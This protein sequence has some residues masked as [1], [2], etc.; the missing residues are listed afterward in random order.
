MERNY[1]ERSD[2]VETKLRLLETAWKGRRFELARALAHSIHEAAVFA[3]QFGSE[4]GPSVIGG[5]TFRRIER[6]PAPWQAWAKG[7]THVKILAVDEITSTARKGEPVEVRLAFPAGQVTSLSREVRLA[8]VNQL[9]GTLEEVLCQVS[10]EVRRGN[11][12]WCSLL[13][14]ADVPAHRREWYLIFYGNR[15][16]ELPEFP[17]DL[18]V[19]GEGVGLDIENSYFRA[20]LSRQMGQ[21][22]RLSM[23][24]EHSL[25]LYSGGEGHGEPP[26]IDW[27]HD[28]VTAGNFQKMRFTNWASCPDYSVTRGPLSVVVRRWGFPHS[29]VH[30]LFTPSRM[31]ITVEYRFFA[32]TPYFLKQGTMEMIQDLEITYLRDDEWVFS[33][34]SFTDSVWMG[35]DGKLRIGE[36]QKGLENDLW[37]VGFFN[38]QSRDAFIAL[39]LEHRAEK[40]DG[41]KHSGAPIL[42]YQLH[43]QLWSRWAASGNPKFQKGAILYQKN[44]YSTAPFP[45]KGGAEMVEV[46]RHQLLNPLVASEG[47]F[48]GNLQANAP[49]GRLG[50]PG[51][52]GDSPIPK[53]DIWAALK[54]CKD[55]QL[56][57]VDAN[58]VDMGYIYDVRVR[59]DRVH[60]VMTMPHRGRPKYGFI[61]NPIRKRLLQLRGV[62]D[63][64]IENVWDP[65]WSANRLTD[66][67]GRA[68]GIW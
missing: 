50:R 56:Y 9:T 17:T 66:A 21:L 59:G 44:A 5:N 60:V 33:G 28:Y 61:G 25:E 30:P 12:C 7:W 31:H 55:D 6:L 53:A 24:R 37:A 49:A 20:S 54:E 19:E 34:Y 23:K 43:G 36:V 27:A 46:L 45:E 8:H 47:E 57:T 39:R 13:F 1:E 22:E 15:D 65:P 51:E 16:A 35:S 4:T 58:V 2:S 11:Q 41:L 14:L 63:V 38:R 68:L 26:G 67:G 40:F 10:N 18:R 48:P 42:N 3:E 52:C 32:G 62:R 29:T 64:I